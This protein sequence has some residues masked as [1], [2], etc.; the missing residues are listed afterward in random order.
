MEFTGP[1]PE[2]FR[3]LLGALGVAERATRSR[4]H[5]S[6]TPPA[7]ESPHQIALSGGLALLAQ[8]A[9]IAAL[10]EQRGGQPQDVSVDPREAVFA[11]NPFPWLRRNGRRGHHLDKMRTPCNGYW[12]TR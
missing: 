11:M 4:F 7:L 2:A 5:L 1:A 6:G 9:A 10:W 12:P 3:A 8:G